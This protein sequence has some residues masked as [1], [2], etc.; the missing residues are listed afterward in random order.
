MLTARLQQGSMN[1][2]SCQFEC[3]WASRWPAMLPPSRQDTV[4]VFHGR[5]GKTVDGPTDR[6]VVDAGLS[7]FDPF[8]FCT[9][10]WLQESDCVLLSIKTSL[11][12]YVSAIFFCLLFLILLVSWLFRLA[13]FPPP[14]P[15]RPLLIL[16][17][18]EFFAWRNCQTKRL[19]SISYLGMWLRCSNFSFSTLLGHVSWTH[20]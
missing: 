3:R 13:D 14:L 12:E 18:E 17:Y 20:I 6:C 8:S 2:K 16:Y 10:L 9:G 4:T 5:R 19:G 15:R 7:L 11:E 1:A